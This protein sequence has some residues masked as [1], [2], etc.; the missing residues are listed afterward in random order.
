MY[1]AGF[2]FKLAGVGMLLSSVTVVRNSILLG[3]YK[4]RFAKKPDREE[5]YTN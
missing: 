2:K 4:P 5:T 3:I 1:L